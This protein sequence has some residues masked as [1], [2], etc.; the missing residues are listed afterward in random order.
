MN[1]KKPLLKL[2]VI[3]PF[4]LA[5]GMA[6]PGEDDPRS[7]W[8]VLGR[9]SFAQSG[10]DVLTMNMAPPSYSKEV[11]ALEGKE[12]IIRG[13]VIPMDFGDDYLVISANPFATCFFCGGA[14]PETV[15]EVYLSEPREFSKD[16]QVTVRGILK[17]N[18]GEVEHLTYML[19]D[20]KVVK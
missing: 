20:A 2:L 8:A 19:R 6:I 7:L 13:Y 16:E 1:S 4:L 3:L 10:G 15:M 11:R 9:V 12:I 18:R 17:L 5:M 14:G